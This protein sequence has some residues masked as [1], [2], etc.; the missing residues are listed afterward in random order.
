MKGTRGGH[1]R[2]DFPDRDDENSW[3]TPW[4]YQDPLLSHAASGRRPSRWS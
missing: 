2:E 4:F 1:F 3:S